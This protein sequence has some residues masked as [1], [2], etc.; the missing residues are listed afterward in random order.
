MCVGKNMSLATGVKIF[1]QTISLIKYLFSFGDFF[2]K[3]SQLMITYP[4]LIYIYL[5]SVIAVFS[6]TK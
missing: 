1:G 6:L 5:P 3:N 4:S 2:K